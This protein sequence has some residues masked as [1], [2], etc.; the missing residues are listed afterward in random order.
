VHA[1]CVGGHAGQCPLLFTNVSVSLAGGSVGP[2]SVSTDAQFHSITL[3]EKDA[4]GWGLGRRLMH[5]S[6]LS[7]LHILT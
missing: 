2:R 7:F 1:V 3:A 6:K 5:L 4:E